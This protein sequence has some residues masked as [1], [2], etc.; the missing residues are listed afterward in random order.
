MGAVYLGR[1]AELGRN[2][3]I[4]LLRSPATQTIGAL[5]LLREAHWMTSTTSCC[6]TSRDCTR[7][8]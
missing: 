5:R 6:A 8:R 3:A 2:V 1:D 7:A 4:K